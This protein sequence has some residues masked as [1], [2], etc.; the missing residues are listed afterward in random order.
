MIVAVGLNTVGS[1]YIEGNGGVG[2]KERGI[3]K[4][5]PILLSKVEPL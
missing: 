2:D 1:S 5:K 4:V 3:L